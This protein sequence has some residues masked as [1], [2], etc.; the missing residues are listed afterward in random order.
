VSID[1]PPYASQQTLWPVRL[2]ASFDDLC[3]CIRIRAVVFVI[4]QGTPLDE[5]FDEHDRSAYAYLAI[6]EGE[7]VGTA[8]LIPLGSGLA[9]IGRVAV[10]RRWR[11]KGVGTALMRHIVATH[12]REHDR[13]VL[14]S[15]VGAIPFYERLGF[16]AGGEVFMD[17]GIPH[18]RMDLRVGRHD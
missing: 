15:Q 10:L 16:E 3:A 18:R 5:E 12:G 14:D 1:V 8:R 4:E 9:K 7:A 17:A 11:G 6:H 2:A 13:L